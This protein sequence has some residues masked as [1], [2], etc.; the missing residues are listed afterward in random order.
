M[1]TQRAR[2][3]IFVIDIKNVCRH[4][5][6]EQRKFLSKTQLDTIADTMMKEMTKCL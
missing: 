2:D 3:E 4:F 1:L 6:A 5:A